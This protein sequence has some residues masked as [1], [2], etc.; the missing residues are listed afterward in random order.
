MDGISYPTEQH[1]KN[2]DNKCYIK[3]KQKEKKMWQLEEFNKVSHR[4]KI[5]QM[6]EKCHQETAAKEMKVPGGWPPLWCRR[7]IVADAQK[8]KFS[9]SRGQIC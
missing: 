7:S 5:N 4:T 3:K 1:N 9:S 8:T 6:S 2:D